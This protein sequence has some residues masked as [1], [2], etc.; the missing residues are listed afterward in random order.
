MSQEQEILSRKE[1]EERE[2]RLNKKGVFDYAMPQSW[3]NDVIE[4]TG[5]NPAGHI[6]WFYP[7]DSGMG[8]PE[9]ITEMGD[10]ILAHYVISCNMR[11]Q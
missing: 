3:F 1:R 5:A 11:G 9:P 4:A 2:D 6:V 8:R 10:N 7:E